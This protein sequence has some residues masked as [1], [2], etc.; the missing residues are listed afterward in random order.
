MVDLSKR[1]I[2]E[3]QELVGRHSYIDGED[4]KRSEIACLADARVQA[5]IAAC[6]LPEGAT[7]VVEPW[8]YATDGMFDVKDR[9]VMVRRH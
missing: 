5:E 3:Q 8:T 9:V 6:D 2:V 4:M 1:Q 7:V